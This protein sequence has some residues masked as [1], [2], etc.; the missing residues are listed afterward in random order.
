M[1]N[2]T[3]GLLKEKVSEKDVFDF[4]K[5]NIALDN[6]AQFSLGVV[7]TNGEFP[8]FTA[9]ISCKIAEDRY[10]TLHFSKFSV[11]YS[12]LTGDSSNIHLSLGQNEEAIEIIGKIVKNFG[13][14]LIKDDSKDEDSED[15]ATHYLYN[16]K[17]TSINHQ[18]SFDNKLWNA[19]L[20]PKYKDLVKHFG[21]IKT[22]IKDNPDFLSRE[23]NE[24]D[25]VYHKGLD[26]VGKFEHWDSDDNTVGVGF[27]SGENEY[28]DYRRV[29]ASMLVKL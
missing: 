14:W 16:P 29:T 23:F 8:I 20:D 17:Y 26:M 25:M 3:I 28:E 5:E 11:D 24:G 27:K 4:I 22:L 6:D 2:W 10:R 12:K 13:G 15:F 9:C 7:D 1:S 21:L 18:Q 19:L